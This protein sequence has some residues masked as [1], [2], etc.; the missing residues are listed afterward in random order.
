MKRNYDRG[1]GTLHAKLTT[2]SCSC[3]ITVLTSHFDGLRSDSL[4]PV[5]Y[6]NRLPFHRVKID[7]EISWIQATESPR[8]FLQS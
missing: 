4:S 5:Q 6:V 3:L 2:L 7:L 1:Y 8:G